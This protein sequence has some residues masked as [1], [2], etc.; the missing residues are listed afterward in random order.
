MN[1]NQESLPINLSDRA[2]Y[3]QYQ[4]LGPQRVAQLAPQFQYVP[5]QRSS[6]P[7]SVQWKVPVVDNVAPVYP[8]HMVFGQPQDYVTLHDLHNGR[9]N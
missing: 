4:H 3:F 5:Q 6:I 2:E 1:S 9:V 8:S 7:K